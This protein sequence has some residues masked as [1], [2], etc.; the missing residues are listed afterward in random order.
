[1]AMKWSLN[2]YQTAQNWE[3]DELIRQAKAAGF[4]GIE[5]LMDFGQKHGVEAYAETPWL[6]TVKEKVGASGLEFASVTSCASFHSL[7]DGE[8]VEA[9]NRARKSIDIAHDFGCRH[10]RVL[11]DRVPEDDTRERV[12]ASV[13]ASM[14][15]LA[16][17]AQ[18]LGITV[19][20]EMHGSFTDPE[21][22]VPMAQAVDMPNFGLVFNSQFRENAPTGWRLPT[23]GS[24]RPLYD[25]FRP[26]LTQIHTHQM[27]RPDQLP[28]YQELF[29]LL[30]A[31]GWDGYVAMEAAYTGP[32]PEKV[33]RLYTALFHTMIA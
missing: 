5:F 20:M 24:I 13:T 28:M 12:L 1:M 33:L 6:R 30:K 10:V 19:A 29:R 4:D 9:M 26:Y 3:L 7:D 8:R 11:G 23:G 21:L 14:R 15:E 31:D 18:P 17:F 2:T 16:R 25:Q 32:D 27:E 22:S